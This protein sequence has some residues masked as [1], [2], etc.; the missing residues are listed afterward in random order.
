[1]QALI[2]GSGLLPPAIVGAA[3]QRPV[4]CALEGMGP[5]DLAVDIWFR[6][7]QLGSLL[8]TLRDQ[9]VTGVCMAGAI[10]RPPVD[11]AAIDAATMPLVPII[12]QAIAGGDDG[13]M[14]AVV[15]IFERAGFQITAAH[16][17]AP[18][19]LLPAG[20]P[21]TTHPGDDVDPDVARAKAVHDAIAPL[22][23]G[24]GCVVYKGQV[25]AV[26][27]L[28]GTDWML[29]SLTARPDGAGGV[30]FKA[31]KATQ[32]RRVDLPTI[33]PDTV[34]KAAEAG[35][36]GLVIEAGGV[37]VLDQ[38]AVIAECDRLGLF[39]WVREAAA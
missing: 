21:T 7:E 11:P 26:E 6:I 32:D 33:G 25:L 14:R 5:E 10:R 8:E 16:D 28:F 13:A 38:P 3:S 20:C 35:L 1:M 36:R 18:D 9:G 37:I 34:R 31:P 15:A 24:Q 30:L 17:I 23:V 4:V 2:A 12:Q 27:G 29:S 22:D 19:L 39:L